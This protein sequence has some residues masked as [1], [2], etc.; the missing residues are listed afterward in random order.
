M[1]P[2]SEGRFSSGDSSTVWGE[3]D[4]DVVGKGGYA[5]KKA[6]RWMRLRAWGGVWMDEIEEEGGGGREKERSSW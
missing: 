6:R 2:P 1:E 4:G 5:A 3:G